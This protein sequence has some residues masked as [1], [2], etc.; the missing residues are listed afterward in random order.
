M[1]L[2]DRIETSA[3]L[4]DFNQ[5][6]SLKFERDGLGIWVGF[7]D[8]IAGWNVTIAC[9]EHEKNNVGCSV[10]FERPTDT[11]HATIIANGIS[12]KFDLKNAKWITPAGMQL[13]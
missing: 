3:V 10:F 4:T 7:K 8:A 9:P 5:K 13:V 12:E 11:I 1:H 2:T 6:A